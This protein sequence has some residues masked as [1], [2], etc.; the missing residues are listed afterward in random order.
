[1]MDRFRDGAVLLSFPGLISPV[2]C[3][4][5]LANLAFDFEV[6]LFGI[7]SGVYRS[8]KGIV[9]FRSNGRVRL[10]VIQKRYDG[11]GDGAQF[12]VFTG[13]SEAERLVHSHSV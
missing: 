13:P 6:Y 7:M 4:L 10:W 5:P 12:G 8:R 11:S 3:R 9:Q 1:M 2:M